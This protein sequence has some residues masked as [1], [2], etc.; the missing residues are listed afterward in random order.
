MAFCH[1]CGKK[2]SEDDLFC[3]NCGARTKKGIEAGVSAPAEEM[4]EAFSKMGQEMEKAFAVAAK[5]IHEAFKT[6]REN[7]RQSTGRETV[8]CSHCG[9]KNASCA[10]YCCKCGEKIGT[11]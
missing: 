5:E 8:V 11:E 6:A 4:R 3:S 10:S 7:I 1:K 9:E 2:I